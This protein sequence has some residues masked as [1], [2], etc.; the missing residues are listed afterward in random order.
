MS[1]EFSGAT[2]IKQVDFSSMR[3]LSKDRERKIRK[4]QQDIWQRQADQYKTAMYFDSWVY[5]GL[6]SRDAWLRHVDHI[7]RL[8]CDV[9][10]FVDNARKAY[11]VWPEKSQQVFDAKSAER[12]MR[13]MLTKWEMRRAEMQ[14]ANLD[15]DADKAKIIHD[16]WIREMTRLNQYMT[17]HAKDA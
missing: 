2:P 4:R 16:M 13:H 8:A 15:D 1:K 12:H 10:C 3:K 7:E 14:Q 11:E 9:L 5:K 17:D 6:R